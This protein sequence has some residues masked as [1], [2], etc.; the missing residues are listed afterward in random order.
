MVTS[1]AMQDWLKTGGDSQLDFLDTPGT[2]INLI[3]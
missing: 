2:P 3:I 1:E